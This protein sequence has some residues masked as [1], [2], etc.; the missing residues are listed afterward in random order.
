MYPKRTVKALAYLLAIAMF[1]AMLPM[2]ALSTAAAAPVTY[3]DIVSGATAPVE[4]ATAKE[5][6][7]FRFVPL[8][9]GVY[10]F[11]SS[12][13]TGDPRGALLDAAGQTIVYNDDGAGDMNF[14]LAHACTAGEVYY[15]EARMLGTRIG[16]Y[17]LHVEQVAVANAA[18][19]LATQDG[20]HTYTLFNSGCA[21]G[22][23]R[24]A[25]SANLGTNTLDN[26]G[27]DIY[28][29][30]EYATMCT[31]ALGLPFTVNGDVNANAKLTVYAYDVDDVDGER[32]YLYLHDETIDQTVALDAYL[33]GESNEWSTTTVEIASS[34]LT[35]G[36][37]YSVVLSEEA[38]GWDLYVRNVS[39]ELDIGEIVP[40][41]PVI[42]EFT[43]SG[44]ITKDGYV[45][46]ALYAK[47]SIAAIY[48]VDCF[49]TFNGQ[50][51]GSYTNLPLS[52]PADGT[53]L[54]GGF[55]LTNAAKGNYAVEVVLRKAD[56]TTAA[57]QTI[58]ANWTYSTVSYDANGGSELLPTDSNKYAAGDTVLVLFDYIPT[59]EGYTFLG[60]ATDSAA[61]EPDFVAGGNSTLVINGAD[62]VLYAVWEQDAPPLVITGENN[63]LIIMD[64]HPWQSN[65]NGDLQDLFDRLVQQECLASYEI[66][67]STAAASIDFSE[68]AMVY[69]VADDQLGDTYS[70]LAALDA[71]L[72][73]YVMAGGVVLYG[74][75][76]RGHNGSY[77]ITYD[78]PGG[79]QIVNT[80]TH[81]G[82]I[83]DAT[84]PVVSAIYSNGVPLQNADLVGSALSHAYIKESTLPA[85]H[86]VILRGDVANAPILAEYPLGEG[87][88][89]L[90]TMTWIFYADQHTGTYKFSAKA[91]DDLILYAMNDEGQ[92]LPHVHAYTSNVVP[93]TCTVDGYTEYACSCGF[94]YTDDV[95]EKLGHTP[96]EWV[97]DTPATCTTSGRKHTACVTCGEVLQNIYIP[98]HGHSYE[99]AVTREVTCTTPG[100]ITYTCV[101]C[102]D[103]Y[104]N[105]VY[106]EH[107]Y[108]ITAHV[109]PTCTTDGKTT[110]TCDRCAD[111][112]D[113]IIPGMHDYIA[114][115]TQLATATSEG[116][117]TYTCS[118]CGDVYTEIIP[119]RPEANVLLIQDRLPW[120]QN[121]N[122]TLLNRLLADGYITGWDMTTTSAFNTVNL[123]NY[124]VIL[125]ANDQTTASYN[126]L[127]TIS[128]SI[129]AFARA[130]GVVIYGACD[131]GWAGGDIYHTLPEGVEKEN[132]YSRYNYILDR[133]HAIVTGILT[134][135]K[136]LTDTL[137]YGNYCSHTYFDKNT[138]PA[139]TNVI[140]Q[141]ANGN[142]TLMEYALGAGHV[143][144][145]GLTWEFYYGRNSYA[146]PAVTYSKNVFDDLVVYAVYLS[147]ACDHAYD[148]GT[149]V[150]PTC[151]EDG[152][153]LHTCELCGATMKDTYV[154]AHG[155]TLGA[156][157]L[158]AS[159]T[160]EAIGLQ[161]RKCTVCGEVVERE[162]L[163]MIDAPIVR[164]EAMTDPII[165]GETVEVYVVI[166]NAD[167]IKSMA[168]VPIF[169]ANVFELVSATWLKSA[170]IQTIEPDTN[171]AASAW[172]TATDV[173]G[174][175][176]KIV[177]L[178]TALTDATEITAEVMFQNESVISLSVVGD[179]VSVI[180]CPHT[181]CT[182]TPMNDD[183][184]ARTCTRCGYSEMIAHT[185]DSVCDTTCDDCGHV[186][187]A[188]H[189]Y[190]VE[191]HLDEHNHWHVC[192]LCGEIEAL[193]EHVYDDA[194]DMDC[195][196][197]GYIRYIVGD[198]DA[199]GDVDSDDAI[200]LL[201]YVM[202]G[203][204]DYPVNQPC[205]FDNDG[206]VDSDDACRIL[207]YIFYGPA[208][209]PMAH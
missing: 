87:K 204:Q 63:V 123:A 139:G 5:K 169:D 174:R 138:L 90:T 104:A 77:D 59:R 89:I 17:A 21:G 188:P 176:F 209:Y 76:S 28:T 142:P 151:V 115:I 66:I 20:T 173:N 157:E 192:T 127:A 32:A 135:G 99:S 141:D 140:L 44:E 163:P 152:Y 133:D 67:T 82:T 181:E 161:V 35:A 168:I 201:Y 145:T 203:A 116:L 208:E 45:D 78:L 53:S 73:A 144:A 153:T 108:E 179:T 195:D 4:I 131:N 102:G 83:A 101:H 206:D 149:V 158:V 111:S 175:I 74:A 95:I 34:M 72:T 6:V 156:W 27:Y 68:Y 48:Y 71:K 128:A 150:P 41:D 62:V 79:V 183:Y 91:Y 15:V 60:W 118:K 33:C 81:N 61:T 57:T 191:W 190:G 136:A 198:V 189:A 31:V 146:G 22:G 113:E 112:Y 165:I 52:V 43:I 65:T 125:I 182:V 130:G 196:E 167:P 56:G 50:P 85:G 121:D 1:A 103:S 143:I 159:P 129:T 93:P 194:H 98:A 171:R 187:V 119:M 154:A 9:S 23:N 205:D 202:F 69:V 64:M 117:I 8:V 38:L 162:V 51:C 30:T 58:M 180:T 86:Q 75:C 11:Y 36:H 207:Y 18:T 80:S 177:L 54:Q 25:Y 126:Q 122:V 172:M 46:I 124:S 88:V 29:T 100:I 96:G 185:Y 42:T 155:H 106:S 200:Y 19:P 110:Y 134:D 49:A 160:V 137:L 92:I 170:T 55:W 184:H 16:A 178:A 47:S 109:D 14:S 193:Y 24:Y 105:Y 114:E 197:C 70:R 39:L 13:R 7:Y 120:S 199:D 166:E 37:T 2:F 40:P 148:E 94:T 26:G 97:I 12:D 147:N 10:R 186:R 132:F 164:V 107:H 84:H 3:S